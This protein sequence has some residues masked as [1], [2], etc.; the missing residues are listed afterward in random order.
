MQIT[1]TIQLVQETSAGEYL[2][3]QAIAAYQLALL[4]NVAIVQVEPTL[5]LWI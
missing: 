3:I 5:E 1:W 2:I 4:L